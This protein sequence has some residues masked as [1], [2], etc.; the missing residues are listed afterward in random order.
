MSSADAEAG[1]KL[2]KIEENKQSRAKVYTSYGELIN[3]LMEHG[4]DQDDPQ[5]EEVRK[6]SGA[7]DYAKALESAK[8][9][10]GGDGIDAAV[11]AALAK[12]DSAKKKVDGGGTV[13]TPGLP[14][15]PTE[16]RERLKD[17][18]WVAEHRKELLQGYKQGV[19]R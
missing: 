5:Y 15:D 8:K 19:V 6:F 14:T 4:I 18:A 7:G 3:Y 9:A 11:E 12:R 16:L 13:G 1:Q 10:Q 17:K 2:S